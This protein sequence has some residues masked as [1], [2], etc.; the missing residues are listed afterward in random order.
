MICLVKIAIANFVRILPKKPTRWLRSCRSRRKD[1][2]IG[3]QQYSPEQDQ[4]LYF[5]K[6]SLQYFTH[7]IFIAYTEFEIFFKF[8]KA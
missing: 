6:K 3:R 4:A 8:K 7:V 2:V 1:E 5:R